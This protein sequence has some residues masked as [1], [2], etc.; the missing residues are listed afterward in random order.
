MDTGVIGNYY[1][2]PETE[3]EGFIEEQGIYESGDAF[4]VL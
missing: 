4:A 2:D 1:Y 3:E